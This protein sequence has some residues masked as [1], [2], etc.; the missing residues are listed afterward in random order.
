[1]SSLFEGTFCHHWYIT[2]CLAHKRCSVI[3]CWTSEYWP[4][5]CSTVSISETESCVNIWF[6]L[7]FSSVQSLSRVRL[8]TTPWIT[9]RQ[10]SLSITNSRSSPRLTSIESFSDHLKYSARNSIHSKY[11]AKRQKP[12]ERRKF[13]KVYRKVKLKES[14]IAQSSPTLCSPMD[15]SP[16]GSSIHGIFQARVLEGGPL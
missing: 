11:L 5:V 6:I 16:P 4:S 9:A 8:F 14:E 3:I 2:K 10:A 13:P 12:T 7:K 1:M 15:C